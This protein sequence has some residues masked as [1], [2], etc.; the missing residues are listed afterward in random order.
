MKAIDLPLKLSKELDAELRDHILEYW[1]AHAIDRTHGGFYGRVNRLNRPVENA[2]KSSVLNTRILWTFSAAYRL[3]GD[4]RYRSIADHAYAYVEEKFWDHE[5]G[6][7]YWM[8]DHTGVPIDRKKHNYAQAFAL[9]GFSEYYRATGNQAALDCSIEI[10]ALL[11]KHCLD[12]EM[13]GYRE[14]F[15]HTWNPLTDARLDDEA[16]VVLRS[17]NTHLHILEA[18]TNLY[19]IWLD[20]LLLDRQKMLTELFLG[21]IYDA[22]NHHFFTHFD[23]QW[24][25]VDTAYSYGH[26]IEASWLLT[27]AAEVINDAHLITAT[28]RLSEEIAHSVLNEGMDKINGGVFNLGRGG[29]VIDTDKQW[30]AQAEAIVGFF[31]AYQKTGY[32]DFLFAASRIWSFAKDKVIDR[33]HGE[34]FYRLSAEGKPN[35]NEDKIGPWKCPYH[36]ARACMEI[37]HRSEKI[38]SPSD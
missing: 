21:E 29:E 33:K 14:A 27:E 12:K 7:V 6:G 18:F 24:N 38:I 2:P 13:R 31:D 4:P 20:A 17:M 16:G 5:Y 36:T 3:L 11:E 19:R 30:W 37:M 9:Y 34:W 8:L 26:D 35:L 15:D 10:F 32:E 23:E 22:H 25:V 28:G 1:M